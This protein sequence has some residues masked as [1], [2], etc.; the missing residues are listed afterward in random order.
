MNGHASIPEDL[1]FNKSRKH[2]Q[3]MISFSKLDCIAI[4]Y[5]GFYLELYIYILDKLI[6]N[7]LDYSLFFLNT[8]LWCIFLL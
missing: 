5:N 6:H 4:N 3:L 2:N 7:V 1:K 8:D